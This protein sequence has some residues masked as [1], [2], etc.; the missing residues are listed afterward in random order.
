MDHAVFD[1]YRIPPAGSPFGGI[2]SLGCVRG[3]SIEPAPQWMRTLH[4]TAS[5]RQPSCAVPIRRSSDSR[6]GQKGERVAGLPVQPHGARLIRLARPC[7]CCRFR[8]ARSMDCNCRGAGHGLVPIK[9]D[10]RWAGR[11]APHE[12]GPTSGSPAARQPGSPVWRVAK[13]KNFGCS[14][15]RNP[16]FLRLAR[17]FC[18]LFCPFWGE[19]LVLCG[20]AGTSMEMVGGAGAVRLPSAR[21]ADPR[22][23]GISL[24]VLSGDRNP[25]VLAR[26][27]QGSGRARVPI[28]VSTPCQGC[29]GC[30]ACP[31]R[32][33]GPRTSRGRRG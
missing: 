33:G 5:V 2:G 20:G 3:A 4:A 31:G 24:H 14:R 13:V 29:H 16:S 27:G 10:S 18:S 23:L 7:R 11:F 19:L 15:D 1:R 12:R 30:R 9:I 21:A 8:R 28:P 32:R 25:Q 22:L 26:W 6:Q 17:Q